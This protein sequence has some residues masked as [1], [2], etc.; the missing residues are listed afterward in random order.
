[1]VR[2][3]RLVIFYFKEKFCVSHVSASHLRD[4]YFQNVPKTS[5]KN[6]ISGYIFHELLI[7]TVKCS[8]FSDIIIVYQ[9]FCGALVTF[10]YFLLQGKVLCFAC[11]G[12]S[13]AR[14]LF[15]SVLKTL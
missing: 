2:R 6:K 9:S 3:F 14:C 13:R 11:V 1:M 4:V 12:K 15:Q 8:F 5:W 7:Q 10:S